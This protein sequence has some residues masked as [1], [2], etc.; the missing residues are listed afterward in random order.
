MYQEAAATFLKVAK[1]MKIDRNWTH[2]RL[3]GLRTK[4]FE[5]TS[6]YQSNGTPPDPQNSHIKSKI[7][8]KSN[9]PHRP[10][11]TLNYSVNRMVSAKLLKS[12][13]LLA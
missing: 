10:K 3:L 4:D 11:Y 8:E 1:I 7:D 9:E 2:I 5:S 13:E 12:H 6:R